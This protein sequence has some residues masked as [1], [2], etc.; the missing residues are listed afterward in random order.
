M[1][2]SR[3]LVPVGLGVTYC[4]VQDAEILLVNRMGQDSFHHLKPC[5]LNH[6]LVHVYNSTKHNFM[7]L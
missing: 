6:V 3:L 7:D 1:L 5:V 2:M 4:G